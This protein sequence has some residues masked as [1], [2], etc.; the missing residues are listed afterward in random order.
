[1]LFPWNNRTFSLCI[2]YLRSFTLFTSLLVIL[3]AIFVPTKSHLLTSHALVPTCTS[4]DTA[5]KDVVYNAL[6]PDQ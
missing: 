4:V 1:M 5:F 3:F 6:K 2:N